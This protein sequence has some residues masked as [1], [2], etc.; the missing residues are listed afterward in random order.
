[1]SHV[2]NMTE[3]NPGGLIFRFALPLMLGNVFQQMYTV[4][5]TMVVG[6]ALGVDALAALGASDW[7]NWMLLSICQGLTQGFAILMAQQFGARKE[8]AL[9]HTVGASAVLSLI[10]A[11][12]LLIFSQAVLTPILKLLKTP[13]EILPF[14]ALYLRFMFAGIPIVMVYNF[15][16]SVLRALGDGRTPLY[17][18]IVASII[19]IL[20]DL[21]FVLVFRWGIAGAAIATLIA[22]VCSGFVC[23]VRLSK[24]TLL[25]LRKEH[26]KVSFSAAWNLFRLGTPMAFQNIII[27]VGGLIVQTVV[28]GAGVLFV[29]GFTATNKLYGI[30]E[31]AATSYGYAMVTYTGQ[32]LGAGKLHRVR[33]GQ[34]VSLIISLITSA[35]IAAC[36]ILFGK[37]ILSGFI[38][39]TPEQVSATLKIAYE[40]L[41]I[42]SIFLPVLYILHL[43]RSILQGLGNTLLPMA[44]GIAEFVMRTAAVM[45]LPALMGLSGIF[46]GEVLA[47]VGADIILI[48][49]YIHIMRKQEKLLQ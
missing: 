9:R 7:L 35:C 13:E 6:K 31:I 47:W 34:R 48:P 36:M 16:A 14:T 12:V 10:S 26:F 25:S 11:V 37:V 21:L 27:S 39:G 33:H 17:A 32:N 42:M 41:F 2:K 18:M 20:L 15:F 3:G 22:Q 19:N 4:V 23:Y 43:Y 30:L 1:M 46:Y 49:S 5:D 24:L 28:N 29:A 8:D 38:S 40:Y 44:S 45:V